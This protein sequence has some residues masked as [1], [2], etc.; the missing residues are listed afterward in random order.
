M[1]H[2]QTRKTRN[3]GCTHHLRVFMFVCVVLCV[4]KHRY[5]AEATAAQQVA[6]AEAVGASEA[7]AASH[8]ELAARANAERVA[9]LEADHA[10]ALE[11]QS[12]A[13]GLALDRM[14][15]EVKKNR[16]DARSKERRTGGMKDRRRGESHARARARARTSR[17]VQRRANGAQL[18]LAVLTLTCVSDFF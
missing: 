15:A 17:G 9:D 18:G 12:V 16:S 7:A 5:Q 2:V 3:V 11:G 1:L 14:E 8:A 4:L 10:G 6:V 13:H